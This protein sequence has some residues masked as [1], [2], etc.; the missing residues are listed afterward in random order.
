VTEHYA[1]MSYE[2]ASKEAQKLIKS[3]Y[4]NGGWCAILDNLIELR[5]IIMKA[6]TR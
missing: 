6:H 2:Q 3:A 1:G 5:S 4:N